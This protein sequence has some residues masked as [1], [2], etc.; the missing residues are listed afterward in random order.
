MHS[1]AVVGENAFAH[2]SGI[3]QDGMLKAR[4]TYEIMRA[5]EV[6]WEASR[7]VLGKLSGRNVFRQRLQALA[8]LPEQETE[9]D[10]AFIRFKTLADQQPEISD[11]DLRMLMST[12]P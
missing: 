1:K 12:V 2:A 6:G 5:E 3:H 7:L 4:E 8:I 10:L 9:L 11:H